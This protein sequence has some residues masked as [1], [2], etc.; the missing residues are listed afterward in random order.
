[1]SS[2]DADDAMVAPKKLRLHDAAGTSRAGVDGDAVAA[3]D[4]ADELTDEET[5]DEDVANEFNGL[6]LLRAGRLGERVVAYERSTTHDAATFSNRPGPRGAGALLDELE[7][8]KRNPT[9]A[10]F[11][12]M[13]GH[14]QGGALATKRRKGRQRKSARSKQVSEAHDLM[15][16]ATILYARGEYE[17]AIQ[18][19]HGA[20][21]KIPNSSE[22]YEQL[23]L[24][25]EET[26]QLDKALDCYS[27]A[28]AVK[29]GVD[30]SMWYR[31]ASLAV[32]VGNKEYALH[33]LARAARLDPSN[34][35][36]KLDQATLYR[37]LGDDKKAL[38]QLEWILRDD[39]SKLDG[40][41]IR[42][43]TVTLAK[44]CYGLGLHEKAELALQ[45]MVDVH[46]EHIDATVVN[47]LIEL[48]MES[49][50]YGEAL[51]VVEL[52]RGRIEEDGKL[53]LDISVK[54]GQCL[55]YEG[56]TNEGMEYVDELLSHDVA[57]FDDLFFD[58]GNTC[59]EIGLAAKAEELFTPL[60]TLDDHDN[61]D[62][63]QRIAKCIKQIKGSQGV[64]DFYNK[65]YE[66]YPHDGL[67]VTSLADALSQQTTN[68]SM[69]RR[70]R[71]LIANL[72][73]TE[74]EKYGLFLR[75][76]ALQRKLLNEEELTV[77]IPSVFKLLEELSEQRHQRKL[78]RAGQADDT[79]VDDHV[80][81]SDD[82]VF[83]SIISGA[84][85]A[86]RL[87]RIDDASAIVN[88]ALSFSAGSVLT[89][90]QTASLRY[91]KALVSYMTGDLQDASANC[92]NV[93]EVFPGS[94]TVW[95]MLMHM[96]V[97]YPRAL[98]VGS[99]K[100][101]KKLVSQSLDQPAHARLVPLMASGHVHTWN[102]KW[103][104]AMHDFLT[105]LTLAPNDHEVTLT[106]AI[107]LLHM[108][109]RNSNEQQRHSWA[110]RAIVLLER[111][112]EL[113][114]AHPQRGLYNLARGLHH[115]G[116]S[117]LA[118]PIYER[119]LEIASDENDDGTVN[120][121]REAA[122]NLS[123]IYRKAKAHGLARAVLRKYLTV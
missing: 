58:C 70:A 68:A 25:Y 49:H 116:W 72:E 45:R 109:T 42:D 15:S 17:E 57:E 83:A 90:E 39:L 62:M 48:K 24:V 65:L 14:D 82:A 110:L 47:I 122:Y 12:R 52:T 28:T 19:L 27:L 40:G 59:M 33:C 26:K 46:I 44:V 117:H 103:S 104:I 13:G 94:V 3:G 80:R 36:N 29:R 106:A 63:W 54:V 86:L 20:I 66:Q 120:V 4:D 81:I 30:Q 97:N 1:M 6:E 75:V 9:M 73:E 2:E 7:S 10:A 96:A 76:T 35:E 56:R 99:S 112:A 102:K 121:S 74:I 22:P 111:S 84:E 64:V 32:T 89:R 100:L 38:D 21:V 123:L 113:N 31:M 50:K 53:P 8:A 67:V 18:A 51:G 71:E 16:D 55:L 43:S 98:S 37:D 115:L 108:A 5:S 118:R 114:S 87:G 107:S 93:L 79:F 60:L 11:L 61:S 101:A 119:C 95:N 88:Q 34:Y 23:A 92:R 78:Q 41:V 91:L 85:V 77:I 105:A 69:L